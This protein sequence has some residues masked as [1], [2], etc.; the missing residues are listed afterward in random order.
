MSEEIVLTVLDEVLEELKQAN[1]S[2]KEMGSL[3]QEL[4]MQVQ[5]FDERSKQTT[6]GL[7]KV[8]RTV[9]AQPKAIVRRIMLF[10]ENDLQ[11]SYKT[12]IHWLIGGV[13]AALVLLSG[14]V[15]IHEWILRS[16]PRQAAIPA[17]PAAPAVQ[18]DAD[19]RQVPKKI[20]KKKHTLKQN[21]IRVLPDSNSG[22]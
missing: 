2:L 13:L 19:F 18:K 14:Y 16:Y 8:M 7:E 12:F 9:E 6:E 5:A 20:F 4:K 15:L 22:N 3:V 1:R 17:A 21:D 11:G 10:P